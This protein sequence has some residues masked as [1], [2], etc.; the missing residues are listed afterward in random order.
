MRH[1]DESSDHPSSAHE[2]LRD[3]ASRIAIFVVVVADGDAACARGPCH[4]AIIQAFPSSEPESQLYGVL[5][6]LKADGGADTA[7]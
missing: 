4:I 5:N 6:T 7:F 2:H 1:G 3:E